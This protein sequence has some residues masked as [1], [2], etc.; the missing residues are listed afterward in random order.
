YDRYLGNFMVSYTGDAYWQDVLDQ[1]FAG[2][3]DAFTLVN[4][5][6]GVKF[7]QDRMVTTVKINNL[8][9]SEVQ[10]HIFGDII[11]RQVVGELK[12]GF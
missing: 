11:K 12:Y 3:T 4:V 2:T 7:A 1:R 8:L 5:G 9:N 10:Q 6:F